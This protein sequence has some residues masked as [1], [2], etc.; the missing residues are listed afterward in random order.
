MYN[1]EDFLRD[2]LKELRYYKLKAND[3]KN[4]VAQITDIVDQI[5]EN[6]INSF[7]S[8]REFLNDLFELNNLNPRRHNPKYGKKISDVLFRLAFGFLFLGFGLN[9]VMELNIKIIWMIFL[10]IFAIASFFREKIF[11]GI[12]ALGGAFFILSKQFFL[13]RFDAQNLLSVVL[14]AIFITI[15]VKILFGNKKTK[16]RSKF[17]NDFS[18][19]DSFEDEN[20]SKEKVYSKVSDDLTD[21]INQEQ[22][23]RMNAYKYEYEYK[24]NGEKNYEYYHGDKYQKY[25]EEIPPN[26]SWQTR[27]SEFKN[28]E[29]NE[30]LK[31]NCKFTGMRKKLTTEIVKCLEITNVCGAVYVDL[32]EFTFPKGDLSVSLRNTLGG[33]QV[34]CNQ[35]TNVVFLQID[36]TLGGIENKVQNPQAK[37]TIYVMGLNELSGIEFIQK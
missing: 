34:Y 15:A 20:W 25:E 27:F 7:G 21:Q 10:F 14:A 30:T 9:F 1:K 23:E 35:D 2:V 28:Y 18:S 22:F 17:S 12:I 3:K 24:Y 33:I 4:I 16:K 11:I 36:N 31:L 6:E 26:G 19:Y 37:N 8:P 5:N 29:N 32:T 13:A